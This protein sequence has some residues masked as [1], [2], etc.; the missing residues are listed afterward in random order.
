M[1]SRIVTLMDRG[2]VYTPAIRNYLSK[3]LH[4][5]DDVSV[6]VYLGYNG[7]L[8]RLQGRMDNYLALEIT[9]TYADIALIVWGGDERRHLDALCKLLDPDD[10][11]PEE[12][13]TVHQIS[14]HCD[15]EDTTI[16]SSIRDYI[17]VPESVYMPRPSR[18]ASAAVS[19]SSTASSR[20]YKSKTSVSL[21]PSI[22]PAALDEMEKLEDAMCAYARRENKDSDTFEQNAKRIAAGMKKENIGFKAQQEN[23]MPHIKALFD[24][25]DS[26]LNFAPSKNNTDCLVSSL[27]GTVV[28]AAICYLFFTNPI[29]KWLFSGDWLSTAIMVLAGG[30]GFLAASIIGAAIGFFGCGL[31]FAA[32]DLI[33]PADSAI[34]WLI[35]IIA[36]VAA[37]SFLIALAIRIV[38]SATFKTSYDRAKLS[39]CKD[40][41][42]RTQKR[43]NDLLGA[44]NDKESDQRTLKDYYRKVNEKLSA[45]LQDIDAAINGKK[46]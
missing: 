7:K 14:Q 19:T 17:E 43:L 24:D 2:Y 21:K 25:I 40:K 4:G 9:E 6:E 41:A 12:K 26:F 1:L 18:S 44:L 3:D 38:R 28:C 27:I 13:Q 34:R 20:D 30:I 5:D 15:P 33:A 42:D 22:V 35:A 8:V 10:F 29:I 45:R 31:L 46:I 32:V 11:T 16:G 36:G 37:V 23:H 39:D